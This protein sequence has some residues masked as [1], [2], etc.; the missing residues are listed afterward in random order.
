MKQ[1]ILVRHAQAVWK[2]SLQ[3]D[4]ERPLQEIGI[5]DI[6]KIGQYLKSKKYFPDYILTSG[7]QRTLET[8]SIILKELL[9]TPIFINADRLIY[10][11]SINEMINLI[12]K[13]KAQSNTA[14]IVG[15]NPT[16]TL[17]NNKISNTNIDHMPTSGASIINY[18]I[19][20]WKEINVP[21]E[22]IEF[23]YPKKLNLI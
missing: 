10:G 6:K 14:M 22:L 21:G 9:N 20:Q 19:N 13:F 8:A 1:L 18:N 17:L 23:I 2:D 3:T 7:A 16:I 15:H 11:A 12:K 4:Y 5:Q